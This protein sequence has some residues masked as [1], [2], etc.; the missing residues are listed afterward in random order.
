[1]AAAT[2]DTTAEAVAPGLADLK[3]PFE[4][5]LRRAEDEANDILDRILACGDKPLIARVSLN[6][7]GREVATEDDVD[8]LVE[9][10]R[11]RLVE[12]IRTGAR[13]RIL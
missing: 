1:M 4:T 9:E 13:V 3:D 10:V 2:T 6:L 5:R 12:K 7:R 11:E 8:A